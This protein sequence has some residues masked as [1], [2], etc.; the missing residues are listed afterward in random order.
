MRGRYGPYDILM[1][2]TQW[3]DFGP[4]RDRDRFQSAAVY[5]D[6]DPARAQQLVDTARIRAA[7]LSAGY[8]TY[9]VQALADEGAFERVAA[10]LERAR[11]SGVIIAFLGLASLVVLAL[12]LHGYVSDNFRTN[13]KPICV[14][15][16]FGAS[17]FDI[18]VIQIVRLS[19]ILAPALVLSVGL[20]CAFEMIRPNLQESSELVRHE[21]LELVRHFSFVALLFSGLAALLTLAIT[22][23]WVHQIRRRSLA[24]QLKEL[25]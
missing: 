17:A 22:S 5:F 2:G 3:R 11:L 6:V 9:L 24:E 8:R 20:L 12:F 19:L 15:L 7:E 18:A 25:D 13:L 14:S 21:P 16:A 1:S 4:A 23:W 10:A